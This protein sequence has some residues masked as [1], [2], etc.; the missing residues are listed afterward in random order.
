MWMEG[1]SPNALSGC[2][3]RKWVQQHNFWYAGFK[4][5]TKG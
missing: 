1:S 3:Q 4:G 5:Y 2:G